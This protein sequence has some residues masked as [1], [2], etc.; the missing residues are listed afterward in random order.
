VLADSRTP[1]SRETTQKS[2]AHREQGFC[3]WKLAAPVIA[4]FALSPI[5]VWAA[6]T[7][8]PTASFTPTPCQNVTVPVNINANG[9]AE[10]NACNPADDQETAIGNAPGG[11]S[12]SIVV[13]T[14]GSPEFA[15]P[16]FTETVVAAVTPAPLGVVNPCLAGGGVIANSG[17]IINNGAFLVD[18]YRSNLGTYNTATDGVTNEFSNGGEQAATSILLNGSGQVKGPK[19]PNDPP[20]FTPV[21]TPVLTNLVTPACA[22]NDNLTVPPSADCL[23]AGNNYVIDNLTINGTGITV[24][25]PAGNYQISNLSIN[26]RMASLISGPGITSWAPFWSMEAATTSRF[27]AG[28]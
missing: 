19:L 20:G 7:V 17:G 27:R 21:P 24:N 26:G 10:T 25:L 16:G 1:L 22:V 18:S 12:A 6:P 3:F 15:G 23:T 11:G 9:L 14:G 28:K 4:V 13:M 8:I 5:R 2:L